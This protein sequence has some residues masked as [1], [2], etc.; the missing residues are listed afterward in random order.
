MENSPETENN[1]AIHQQVASRMLRTNKK[2]AHSSMEKFQY[3]YPEWNNPS[4]KKRT[5]YLITF[6]ESSRKFK[7]I[8]NE[9]NRPV[10][11]WWWVEGQRDCK[12]AKEL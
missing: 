1:L 5:C 12:V 10:V 4:N 8:Y 6:I 9:E 3:H 11:T 2:D 7:L